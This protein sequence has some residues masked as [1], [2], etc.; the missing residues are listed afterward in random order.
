MRLQ[1]LDLLRRLLDSGGSRDTAA[2]RKYH[3][4]DENSLCRLSRGEAAHA[5]RAPVDGR[6]QQWSARPR[7]ALRRAYHMR[8]DTHD[9]LACPHAAGDALR[10]CPIIAFSCT[11][12]E[13]AN[14]DALRCRTNVALVDKCGSI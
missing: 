14:T 1:K 6:E 3:N 9:L 4:C 5:Q 8:L 2:T 7:L 11:K 13:E 10:R 12:P